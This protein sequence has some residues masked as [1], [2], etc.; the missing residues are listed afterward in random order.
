MF[1][2]SVCLFFQTATLI[3]TKFDLMSNKSL[4]K[5][6]SYFAPIIDMIFQALFYR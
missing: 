6:I 1:Q 2:K 5:K 3:F 4:V